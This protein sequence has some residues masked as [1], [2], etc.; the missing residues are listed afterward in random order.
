MYSK[1]CNERPSMMKGHMR[2]GPDE[3]GCIFHIY[4]PFSM[5][6]FML[7]NCG[8]QPI[9]NDLLLSEIVGH[10]PISM[11]FYSLKLWVTTH[12]Q[13]AF[14]LWN[15]GS[16]TLSQQAGIQLERILK[17][18]YPVT[19]Q[20][21]VYRRKKKRRVKQK[22]PREVAHCSSDCTVPEATLPSSP[23]DHTNLAHCLAAWRL[24]AAMPPFSEP[25][26]MMAAQTSPDSDA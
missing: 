18:L 17:V 24:V 1:M 13:R 5:G 23:D 9:F 14:T 12:F 16:K 25:L 22:V 2:E 11:A 26:R 3:G 20:I 7:W 15:C 6:F 4:N 10:N 19:F 21:T 8:S